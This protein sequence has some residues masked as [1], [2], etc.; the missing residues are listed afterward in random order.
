MKPKRAARIPEYLRHVL[1]A[2]DRAA[3]YVKDM[4]LAAFEQDPVVSILAWYH[5]VRA[6]LR[7]TVGIGFDY[8]IPPP[9]WRPLS[10]MTV[11]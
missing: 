11:M 4:D 9:R 8:P 10:R 5:G 7:V 3:S 1:D 6:L 2:I